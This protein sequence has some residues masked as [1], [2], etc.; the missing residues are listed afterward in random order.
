M[1]KFSPS[2]RGKNWGIW[3]ICCPFT[4]VEKTVRSIRESRI[5]CLFSQLQRSLSFFLCI[6]LLLSMS[7]CPTPSIFP[8]FSFWVFLNILPSIRKSHSYRF[9]QIIFHC[10]EFPGSNQ[11]T[12]N[13]RGICI[14]KINTGAM[15]SI[16]LFSLVRKSCWICLLLKGFPGTSFSSPTHVSVVYTAFCKEKR[17]EWLPFETANQ[18]Y[19]YFTHTS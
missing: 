7:P 19:P 18:T 6:F 16:S 17:K 12:P 1:V 4:S 11:G 9:L 3:L 2:C 5:R 15:S 14:H 10:A 13:L 8:L